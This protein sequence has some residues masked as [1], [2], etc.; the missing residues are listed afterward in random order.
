MC[1]RVRRALARVSGPVIVTLPDGYCL[2]AAPGVVDAM[3]A[4]SLIGE[5]RRKMAG[6]DPDRAARLLRQ[7]LGLWRGPALG[8]LTNRPFAATEASRLEE[9]REAALEDLFDAELALGRHH[10]VVGDLEALVA[11]GALRERRWGQLMV[12]LYRDGRQ[13]EALDAFDRLRQVLSQDLGVDPGVELS[14]LHQAILRQSPGLAWH[15]RQRPQ[16]EAVRGYFGRGREMSRLL[17]CFGDAVAGRGGVVLLAGEPGLGKSHA[18]RQLAGAA[19][20]GSAVVLAG[21]CIEGGWVPPFRPFAEAI[22][23]YGELVSPRQLEATLARPGRR[24]HGSRRGFV[25]CL[26]NLAAPPAWRRG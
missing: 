12:A 20:D 5:G 4:E 24:W 22:A 9:L 16:E 6:G 1:L 13:A 2:R 21:R 25:S 23:G 14:D 15:P 8:E 26:P 3:L 10:E 17:A 11:G 19:R 18:L 7:A